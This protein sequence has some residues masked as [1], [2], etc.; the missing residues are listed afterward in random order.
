MGR[1]EQTCKLIDELSHRWEGKSNSKSGYYMRNARQPGDLN[2]SICLRACKIPLIAC[3][4]HFLFS[5]PTLRLRWSSQRD[6]S[7]PRLP[8]LHPSPSP[9]LLPCCFLACLCDPFICLHHPSG[10]IHCRLFAVS[11]ELST[12]LSATLNGTVMLG[13]C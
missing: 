7:V 13:H 6:P 12:Y 8:S 5:P 9:S 2:F 4:L 10:R 1:L 3:C 11:A